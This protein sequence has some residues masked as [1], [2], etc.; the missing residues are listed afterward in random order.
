[1]KHKLKNEEI[2][3]NFV[4]SI[5]A[6]GGDVII[7][8]GNIIANQV[9]GEPFSNQAIIYRGK[10][11]ISYSIGEKDFVCSFVARKYCYEDIIKQFSL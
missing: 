7:A 4:S 10:N 11:E 5:E 9:K 6:I 8:N 1:M 3:N 2:L